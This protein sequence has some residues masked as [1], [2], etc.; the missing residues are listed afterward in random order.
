MRTKFNQFLSF[1]T[2][3][4]LILS[5]VP[6]SAISDE[7]DGHTIVTDSQSMLDGSETDGNEGES[8]DQS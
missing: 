7:D 2:A 3:L 5:A 8:G 4:M 6:V 1:L